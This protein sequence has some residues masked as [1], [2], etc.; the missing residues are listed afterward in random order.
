MSQHQFNIN[1][2]ASSSSASSIRYIDTESVSPTSS[3][4]PSTPIRAP[5][6]VTYSGDHPLAYAT[7]PPSSYAPS[8]SSASSSRVSSTSTLNPNHVNLSPSPQSTAGSSTSTSTSVGRNRSSSVIR[9]GVQARELRVQAAR[10]AHSS[11][12]IQ[13]PSPLRRDTQPLEGEQVMYMADPCPRPLKVGEGVTEEDAWKRTLEMQE[14][15]AKVSQFARPR[16]VERLRTVGSMPNMTTNQTL[17]EPTSSTPSTSTS[18]ASQVKGSKAAGKKR[19]KKVRE[20]AEEGESDQEPDVDDPEEG[21]VYI[22]CHWERTDGQ[23]CGKL[24]WV[25]A[26]GGPAEKVRNSH[27][28]RDHLAKCKYHALEAGHF[29]CKYDDGSYCAKKKLT[30]DTVDEHV[31]YSAAG[32]H[33]FRE[34]WMKRMTRDWD[35]QIKPEYYKKGLWWN[36]LGELKEDFNI[37]S[38]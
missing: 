24:L 33:R 27:A 7:P 38:F 35:R 18:S 9:A 29:A 37:P 3:T 10:N 23:P 15:A 14:Y 26:P 21:Q 16:Q 1:S 17:P 28:I 8:V 6:R 32:F 22:R 36:L 11:R 34:V 4:F 2:Y 12:P 20:E 5:R 19:A 31:T 25:W 30:L 13:H